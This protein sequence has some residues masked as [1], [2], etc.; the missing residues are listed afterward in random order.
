MPAPSSNRPLLD[1]RNLSIYRDGADDACPIVRDL[2]FKVAPGEV[3]GIRGRSGC[4]KTSTALALLRLLPSDFSVSGSVSFEE[5]DLLKIPESELR[6]IRGHKISIVYQ[7]PAL[8]LNPVMRI[9]DQIGEVLRAHSAKNSA[10]RRE[11][12]LEMLLRVRLHPQRFYGK[13]PHELSGGERHR[14]VLAQALVC[15]PSLII[16]DEPTAG[17]DPA[18]KN[19]ILDLIIELQPE[20]GAAFLLISHDRSVLERVADRTIELLQHQTEAREAET[21]S[22]ILRKKNPMPSSSAPLISVRNLNKWYGS[23]GLFLRKESE[24]RALDSV[25]LNIPAAS[26]VA[27]VGPSGSGKSTLARCLALLEKADSGQ[28]VFGDKDLLRLNRRELR[29]HRPSLQYIA[30]ES[31][32]ALNPRLTAWQAVEE[33][34]LIRGDCSP[35]ERRRTAEETMRSV[36]LDS[37]SGSRSC[38]EFSGGQKQRLLIARALTLKPKLL[39]LDES[40]SGLD[41]ETQYGILDLLIELKEKFQVAQLLISHDLEL[42]ARCADSIAVMQDGRIVEHPSA[43]EIADHLDQWASEHLLHVS[44][45]QELV[46]AEVE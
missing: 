17:L 46:G 25:D 6:R 40:L 43:T 13:Y 32:E 2:S 10:R 42:V 45:R 1:V 4:G 20:I 28:I 15:R 16:A 19:E 23:R 33:P 27:L 39:I 24:K 8:A 36:G 30:Q 31:S 3:L 22:F 41:P 21:A 5:R 18:L 35:A 11:M 26:V 9:G 12:V 37:T 14:A 7:E 34:L 44:A 29:R 38:H